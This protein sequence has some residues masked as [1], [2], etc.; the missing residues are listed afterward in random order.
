[1]EDKKDKKIRLLNQE[2]DRLTKENKR[3]IV[4]NTEL[5]THINELSSYENEE[6]LNTFYKDEEK[7]EDYRFSIE[8]IYRFKN[9]TL[10]E[11]KEKMLA[12]SKSATSWGLELI[13]VICKDEEK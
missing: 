11:E 1:M 9:H 10:D 4:E 7:L 6:K 13:K 5:Q 2:I 12:E 3:L 8:N